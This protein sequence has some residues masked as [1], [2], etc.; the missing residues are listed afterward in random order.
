MALT[1]RQRGFIG[2]YVEDQTLGQAAAAR[3]AGYSVKRAKTAAWE[4]MRNPEIKR[5]I[6]RRL[7]AKLGGIEVRAKSGEVTTES[8]CQDCD[9]VIEQCKEAGPGAWQMQSRLK[10][11]EL[12]AKLS[13]LL[14]EKIE[15]GL[16]EKLMELLEAGRKRAGLISLPAAPPAIEGEAIATAN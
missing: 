7:A 11:I 12:K 4:L 16:D 13:G 6:D 8:L 3:K 9:E 1:K 14:T 15:F 2:A 5:E 10:A